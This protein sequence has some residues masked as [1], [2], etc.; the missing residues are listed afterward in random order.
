MDIKKQIIGIN[1]PLII[2]FNSNIYDYTKFELEKS[3]EN[4]ECNSIFLRDKY[5]SWYI[6]GIDGFSKSLE[7]TKNKLQEDI[8]Q[9][10]PNK[11]ITI[12]LS[13]GG[14]AALY[15]GNLLKVNHII[16]CSPQIIINN[17][18]IK[19]YYNK[20][21]KIDKEISVLPLNEDINI[22]IFWCKFDNF[23]AVTKK[24][25]PYVEQNRND[26]QQYELVKNIKNVNNI[27]VEG[28]NHGEIMRIIIKN[29]ELFKLINNIIL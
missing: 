23:T 13:S 26:E 8:E 20:L 25:N 18:T 28:G 10:K 12:G 15:F 11:I 2:I 22:D 19:Y 3:L 21:K 27:Q 5:L 24:Q 17:N 1:K 14:F 9:I 4:F 7:E 16:A 6:N 29:G